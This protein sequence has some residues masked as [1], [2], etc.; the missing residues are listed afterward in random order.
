M[1]T[2]NKGKGFARLEYLN[3]NLVFAIEIFIDKR[4]RKAK[5][6]RFLICLLFVS[7]NKNLI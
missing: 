6:K 5:I 7:L 2:E 1:H 4:L 3:E